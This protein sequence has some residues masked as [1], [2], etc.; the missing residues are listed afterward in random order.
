MQLLRALQSIDLHGACLLRLPVCGALA[1]PDPLLQLLSGHDVVAQVGGYVLIAWCKS[2]REQQQQS[3][4][5]GMECC[6]ALAA[7][8]CTIAGG[9]S[10]I[11]ELAAAVHW[12]V[13]QVYAFIVVSSIAAGRY[14][15]FGV[16]LC[17]M[18]V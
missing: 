17:T 11:G 9:G 3:G 16:Y 1:L 7:V 10:A 12:M 4:V 5:L 13:E 14:A 8:T 6:V 15:R 18:H 2:L